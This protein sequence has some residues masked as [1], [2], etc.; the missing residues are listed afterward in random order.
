MFG[1]RR[2]TGVR[3]YDLLRRPRRYG[4]DLNEVLRLRQP[5]LRR[6]RVKALGVSR[7][8]GNLRAI[9][10]PE[11]TVQGAWA[12]THYTTT[13]SRWRRLVPYACRAAGSETNCVLEACASHLA[14]LALII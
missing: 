8:L 4:L 3:A 7:L 1:A 14:K 5:T 6:G 11:A 12:C 9:V 13:P 10:P 2:A